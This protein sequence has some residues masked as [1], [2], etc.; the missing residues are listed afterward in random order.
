MRVRALRSTLL[1][2]ALA[3]VAALGAAERLGAQTLEGRVL[4]RGF[5]EPVAL[6]LVQLFTVEG[7]SIDSALTDEAGRFRLESPTP[8]SFRLGVTGLGIQPTVAQ[9]ILDL[10]PGAA[11]SLDFRVE[12][13]PV[14]IGGLT[15]TAAAPLITQGKLVRNGFVDRLA[16]GRGRFIVPQDVE[17]S[18][19]RTIAA[20]LQRT[21]RVTLQSSIAGEQL[22][23]LGTRGYCQPVVYVDGA[24][25]SMQGMSLDNWVGINAFEAAEVYRSETEAPPQFAGGLSGCGVVV[26]WTRGR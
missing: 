24:R 17:R 4:V 16:E 7:D 13:I 25:I 3:A 21:G 6:G 5:D 9:S 20:L 10:G 15:V 2:S 19:E 23:M 1:T 22:L 12:R 11:M 14:Q 26:I 18:G 8:G